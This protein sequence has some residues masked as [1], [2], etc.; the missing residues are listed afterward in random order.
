[1]F[2]DQP[3]RLALRMLGHQVYP[4]FAKTMI[5]SA[6]FSVAGR[7]FARVVKLAARA[8]G[9]S[10]SPGS[11]R[12]QF[13]GERHVQ[14][15]LRDLWAFPDC[16]QIGVW[17]GGMHVCRARGTIKVRTLGRAD[18]DFDIAWRS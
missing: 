1:M 15:E 14:V 11:I 13:V 9:V 6:I 3:L 8:Y 18:I 5:G 4:N 10:I 12:V 2:P 7:D 16:F 17:E